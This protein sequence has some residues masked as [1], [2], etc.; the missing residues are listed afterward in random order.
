MPDMF[1]FFFGDLGSN[2]YS[3]LCFARFCAR[4]TALCGLAEFHCVPEL[5]WL[6]SRSLLMFAFEAIVFISV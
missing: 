2:Y 1:F 5:I 4:L 6:V 3:L